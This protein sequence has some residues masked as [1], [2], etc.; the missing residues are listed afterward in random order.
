VSQEQGESSSLSFQ[1]S[2]TYL[3]GFITKR[4]ESI[5]TLLAAEEK[6]LAE[7]EERRDT[8]LLHTS[9]MAVTSLR[10]D[11][12][13]HL[14]VTYLLKLLETQALVNEQLLNHIKGIAGEREDFRK[15]FSTSIGEIVKSVLDN[16][17]KEAIPA[18]N[19]VKPKTPESLYA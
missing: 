2:L 19:Q 6:T 18:P 13:L 5:G 4:L 12:G 10:M 17:S 16:L 15:Q 14:M 1:E 8:K 7:A 9:G 3:R 11:E